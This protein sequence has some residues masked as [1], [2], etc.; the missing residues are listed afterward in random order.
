[1]TVGDILQE[2]ADN[3]AKLREM[4]ADDLKGNEYY[5][6][7]YNILR[8]LQGWHDLKLEEIA[9]KLRTHLKMRKSCWNL[10]EMAGKPR[11]HPIHSHWRYGITGPSQVLENVI[12]NI[13][14]CGET[15]YSGM[16]QSYSIQEVMKARCQDL[17][18]LLA[19]VMKMEKATG[20]QASVLY[21]MDLT[22]LKYDKR[23]YTLIVG[24]M[25]ALS[26]FMAVHYVEMI[27]YFVLVNVP[28]VIHFIWNF[29][30]PLLPTRTRQKVRILSAHG[31]RQE[32][33]EYSCAESLPDKWNTGTVQEF[34]NY[35]DLPVPYPIDNY[36]QNCKKEP[37]S[38][39]TMQLAAGKT[40]IKTF[41]LKKGDRFHWWVHADSDFGFGFFYS[42]DREEQ[43]VEKMDSV[44]PCFDWMPAPE[45][46]LDES[47]LITEAGTYRVWLS[48]YRAWWHT[49]HI[50]YKFHVVPSTSEIQ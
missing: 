15:D 40:L 9:R 34:T 43:D 23:L 11:K 30:K 33:L 47:F 49:L 2:D 3:I 46:P 35:V 29:T 36:Y 17:E 41:E 16:M 12:V 44:Y 4:L 21:V 28:T 45:V 7:D 22:G 20:K 25:R 38:L 19:E 13:E 27:K 18:D 14:Q 8:W 26:E 48:N 37:E 1:M 6:T 50:K 10:N 42:K 31:W 24:A 39:D 32:I 5:D